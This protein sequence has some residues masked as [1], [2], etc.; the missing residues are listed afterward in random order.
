MHV[1]TIEGLK[2]VPWAKITGRRSSGHRG[3]QL[4]F[5]GTKRRRTS[6]S[7]QKPIQKT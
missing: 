1:S 4:S 7:G 3:L 5:M 2:T 6:L